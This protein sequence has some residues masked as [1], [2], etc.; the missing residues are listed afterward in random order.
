MTELDKV[1]KSFK[2]VH[3]FNKAEKIALIHDVR[4]LLIKHPNRKQTAKVCSELLIQLSKDS[5]WIVRKAVAEIV[6]YID[7]PEDFEKISEVLI[8]DPYE[9]V[10]KIAREQKDKRDTI[11]IT[12]SDNEK[13]REEFKKRL[14]NYAKN[15]TPDEV[16]ELRILTEIH[17][18]EIISTT[19]HKLKNL[20]L[21]M[22][23]YFGK[24]DQFINEYNIQDKIFEKSKQLAELKIT[25]LEQLAEDL[26]KITIDRKKMIFTQENLKN[27]I[28]EV[29]D[30]IKIVFEEEYSID[31]ININVDIDKALIIEVSRSHIY[32]ALFN[33]IKN[34]CEAQND[35]HRIDIKVIDV[36]DNIRIEVRDY[37]HGYDTH[38]TFSTTYPGLSDKNEGKG[39]GYGNY[40]TA[41]NIH[42]HRGNLHIDNAV[43]P[44]V[45]HI[46][47][48]PKRQIL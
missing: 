45:L 10:N 46:I 1:K 3:T 47:K 11:Y 29:I 39:S 12:E 18:N 43:E 42:N 15:H 37:G 9:Y 36:M 2:M 41:I 6:D 8:N 19:R 24:I 32:D 35:N 30:G 34:G 16:D 38:A 14:Q 33:V 20:V 26:E 7:D 48:I 13:V 17:I 28:N 21:P 23:R 22:K 4:A 5:R 40:I 44:G 31:N 27:I 25:H